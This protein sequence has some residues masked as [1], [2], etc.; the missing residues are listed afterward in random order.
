MDTR[1]VRK[2]VALCFFFFIGVGS[3]AQNSIDEIVENFSTLGSSRFTSVVDRDPKTRKIIK[4][5][6]VLEVQRHQTDKLRKVFLR[7]KDNGSFSHVKDGREETM[8]LTVESPERVR[9]Y[10]LRTEQTNPRFYGPAKVTIIVK[11]NT[12]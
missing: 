11:N 3:H 2:L 6:K 7:E 9:I 1:I 10:M 8:T 5:V 4:V 12:R